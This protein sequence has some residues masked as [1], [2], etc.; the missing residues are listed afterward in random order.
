MGLLMLLTVAGLQFAVNRGGHWKVVIEA[1]EVVNVGQEGF[2]GL[3]FF[4]LLTLNVAALGFAVE[5]F[6]E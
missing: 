5:F 6:Y 2:L 1:S 3:P 4:C